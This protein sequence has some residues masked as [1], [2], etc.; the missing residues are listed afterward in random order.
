[1]FFRTIIAVLLAGAAGILANALA[2]ALFVNPLLLKLAW[3][4]NRYGL[5]IVFAALIPLVYRLGL[6]A[7]GAVA[8]LVLLTVLPALL[9]KLALGAPTA[10]A[11][12]LALNFIYA[13]TAL[14]VYRLVA[15]GSRGIVES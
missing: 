4:P 6:G 11:V 1:M 14:I 12:L 3:V 10:W 13:L 9:V 2:A 15:G 7:W 8:A 5:G